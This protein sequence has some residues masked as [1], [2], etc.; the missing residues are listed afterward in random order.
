[1]RSAAR[2]C[3]PAPLRFNRS[4]AG[5]TTGRDMESISVFAEMQAGSFSIFLIHNFPCCHE[6]LPAKGVELVLIG[7][8]FVFVIRYLPLDQAIIL[9]INGQEAVPKNNVTKV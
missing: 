9:K 6:L 1:M 8:V 3:R 7:V 4:K 2:I 5:W